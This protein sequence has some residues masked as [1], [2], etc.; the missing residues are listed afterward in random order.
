M[1]Y[2]LIR[3]GQG[4]KYIE[5]ARK[6][7]FVAIGWNELP[8]L[9][10]FKELEDLKESMQKL[11]KYTPAQL[12]AQAG[13]VYR[14][15]NIL[16]NGDYVLSPIGE[17]EYVIGEVG[18]YYFNENPQ[19]H[20]P[21]KHRR[22]V[23]WNEKTISKDEM[24]TN[25][26]YA[27]GATL[28]IFSLDKYANEL[29]AII[30]GDTPTP[31][32]Q[33]QR[34]RDIIQEALLELDGREFEEFIRHLLEIIGFEAQTTQYVGDKGI[35][36]TGI[37]N[38]EGI[39]EITLRVQVKRVRGSISNKDILAMRG[40]LAQSEHACF[41][42]LSNFTK[43]AIEEAEAEGKVQVRLLD[44]EDLAG[45]VLKNFD[46]LDEEYKKRFSIRRRKDFNIEDQFEIAK[47]ASEE[48]QE[49]KE[50]VEKAPEWDTLVC[51]AKEGG[52]KM[53]FL[54]QKA[55]WA[56]RIND[57][58]LPHIKYLAMYQV[59]PISGITYY[60]EVDRIEP[61]EEE[62]SKYKLFL[63]GEPI[64]LKEKIGLG[65]NPHLKPQ[66]PRYS[67]IEDIL[68]AQT[69]DDV[70]GNNTKKWTN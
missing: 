20:C 12:G 6:D 11:Y 16:K 65:D 39:A 19:G 49:S 48:K 54:E 64:K 26:T 9:T 30:A 57:K 34:V 10:K 56:V 13:Q 61:Y 41:I 28:T 42:T 60:G 4:S 47:E 21:F 14:F 33:P 59:A 50:I 69:L 40:A 55:W 5:E 18:D 32:E 51:S 68:K 8:D 27:L 53:A 24:S 31:A 15:G 38:A 46:D 66:G 36:V 63:K 7:G 1:S 43:Q 70:F 67:K 35:D 22:K 52:F 45:L 17:G 25:L 29:K 58:Y 62:P 2:Y 23:T 3:V 37:L 44:G